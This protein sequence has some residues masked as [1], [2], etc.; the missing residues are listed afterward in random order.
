MRAKRSSWSRDRR[1]RVTNPYLRR[2]YLW[3]V[4]N[5]P[6]PFRA[7]PSPP[8]GRARSTRRAPGSSLAGVDDNP[9]P[10]RLKYSYQTLTPVISA[11]TLRIAIRVKLNSGSVSNG[12][13][14]CLSMTTRC[15]TPPVKS[16]SKWERLGGRSRA[17]LMDG[18][19]SFS[20]RSMRSK[21]TSRSYR[22]S[23]SPGRPQKKD[24][25]SSLAR[26]AL[27]QSRPNGNYR[28]C[29]DA[30]RFH[31]AG[32]NRALQVDRGRGDRS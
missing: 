29:A 19:Q 22:L 14:R 9:R 5:V 8:E 2:A 7:L 27:R 25:S 1:H 17:S 12:P 26:S 24:T 31:A 6:T 15:Q 30:A 13:L 21:A 16:G 10:I 20:K 18:V 4:R 23:A 11:E 3:P 28:V 32:A